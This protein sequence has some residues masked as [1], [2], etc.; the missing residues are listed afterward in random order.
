MK[1]TAWNA[2]SNTW[3]DSQING[4]K[5]NSNPEEK[6]SVKIKELGKMKMMH[7][8]KAKHRITGAE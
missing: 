7:N 6:K 1:S 8:Y 4:K 2:I 3:N 5:W